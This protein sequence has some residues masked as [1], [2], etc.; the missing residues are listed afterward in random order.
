MRNSFLK[1]SIALIILTFCNPIF[2]EQ[3]P[4]GHYPNVKNK[5][6]VQ[7]LDSLVD[8]DGEWARRAIS[9]KNDIDLPI[10]VVFGNL[11]SL[12]PGSNIDF[13]IGWKDRNNKLTIFINKS[14]KGAPYQ[15]LGALLA[16]ESIH[17]DRKNSIAEETYGWTL[18]AETWIQLKEKYPELKTLSP[19]ENPL[20]DRLNMLE[21]LFR[22]ANYTSRLIERE[23]RSSARYKS[24]PETSPGFGM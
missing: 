22:K 1:I 13:A 21:L 14:L 23:I 16:H 8:T 17:Q 3:I 12:V 24:L 20:V 7:A 5:K 9:G 15:A 19:G 11:S 18:E 10:K 6:L 4:L 2:A